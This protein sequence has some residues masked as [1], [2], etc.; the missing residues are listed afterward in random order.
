MIL[1][2]FLLFVLL[3]IILSAV[4]KVAWVAWRFRDVIRQMKRQYQEGSNT[5]YQQHRQADGS[6][7]TDRR[8]KKEK[9]AKIFED[10]EGEYVDFEE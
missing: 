3:F 10:N 5:A 9:S 8:T 4:F 1:L 2:K 6:I 7:I